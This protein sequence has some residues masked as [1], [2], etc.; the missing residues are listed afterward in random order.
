M[1]RETSKKVRSK[2]AKRYRPYNNEYFCAKE[3]AEL[4]TDT[5]VMGFEDSRSYA[6]DLIAHQ[7]DGKT[8]HC[9][10]LGCRVVV[11]VDLTNDSFTIEGECSLDQTCTKKVWDDENATSNVLDEV[12]LV[13][14]T[15]EQIGFVCAKATCSFSCGYT[16]TNKGQIG[17]CINEIQVDQDK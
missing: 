8:L 9:A 14:P 12:S 13:R 3:L 15:S 17:E 4:A 1:D 6:A 10:R 2:L 16:Y 11:E 7:R 5:T